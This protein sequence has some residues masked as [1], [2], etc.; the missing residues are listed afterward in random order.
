[1]ELPDA[2]ALADLSRLSPF[3]RN[4]VAAM[5]EYAAQRSGIKAPG[6]AASVAS[7]ERPYF[8]SPLKGHRLHLLRTSPLTFRRRNLFVDA[9]VGA[10]V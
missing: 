6:G 10:R 5:V 3:A 2:V 1:M 7:L 4:Y 8:A 9:S